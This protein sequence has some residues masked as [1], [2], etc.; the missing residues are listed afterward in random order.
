MNVRLT[1]DS[2][3]LLEQQWAQGQFRSPE[4]VIERA[5]ETLAERLKQHPAMNLAEFEATLDALAEGVGKATGSA[6]RGDD[7]GRDLSRPRL[8]TVAAHLADTNPPEGL[9][10]PRSKL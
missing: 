5:L 6:S 1:P 3:Q 9:A 10:A 8:M 2:K 7:P 4:E